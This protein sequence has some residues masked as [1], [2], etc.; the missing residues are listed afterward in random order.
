M[1]CALTTG[2]TY[3]SCKDNLSGIKRILFTEY[4]NLDQTN[5]AK[6]ALTA[7]VVTTLVLATTKLFREYKLGREMAEASDNATGNAETKINIYTPTITFT[8]NG[9]TTVQRNELDLL[10]KNYLIA[11]IERKNGTYWIAGLDGGLDVAEIQTAFGKKWEDFSGNIVSLVGK[12]ATRM[13]EVDSSLIAAQLVAA[14]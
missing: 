6:F 4:A 11:I 10:M 7:N 12:S 8:I 1:A 9:F 5:A 13:L 3:D 14:P 2:I